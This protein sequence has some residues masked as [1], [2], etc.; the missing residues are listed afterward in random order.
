MSTLDRDRFRDL[1]GGE[2]TPRRARAAALTLGGLAPWWLKDEAVEAARSTNHFAASA[3]LGSSGP[4]RPSDLLGSC[5]VVCAVTGDFPLLRP[6][7][8]LPLRWVKG[9][10]H[11]HRL[12][13]ALRKL[14]GDVSTQVAGLK[15]LPAGRDGW[16]LQPAF[17]YGSDLS[18]DLFETFD[19]GW[20]ALTGGLIAAVLGLTP[21]TDVWAS[22]AWTGGRLGVVESLAAKVQTATAFGAS[23]FFV[24]WSQ[25][26]EATA[27]APSGRRISAIGSPTETALWYAIRTF[28]SAVVNEPAPPI[29]G[30][31]DEPAQFNT[32]ANHFVTLVPFSPAAKQFYTSHLLDAI[33][34]RYRARIVEQYPD[35]RVR[36]YVTVVSD[37]PELA[38][39]G[40]A[41][42]DA[43]RVLLLHT[44]GPKASDAL[45]CAERLG[46]DRCRIEQ[47]GQPSSVGD[48]QRLVDEF[49]A[50]VPPNEV[51]L[52][53]K[54]GTK[55][56]TYSVIV[57]ARPGN[58][59][60]N[61]EP[62]FREDRRNTPGTEIPELLPAISGHPAPATA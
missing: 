31:S 33:T 55:K 59:L 1:F 61:V 62:E 58:F 7:V 5:W 6:A 54:P 38:S 46:V 36:R 20:A 35:L 23:A 56:M 44:G 47:F 11:S 29:A 37:S 53:F 9:E 50:D 40:A 34:R 22:A 13:P 4:P 16:G 51:V 21:K 26:A 24:H 48:I 43:E 52:D 57:A 42:L 8:V 45:R 39:M 32:C 25:V 18:D 10:S 2:P 27:A 30:A 14:A 3:L 28:A 49:T 60:L 19:S 12:P 41:A 17:E 15:D